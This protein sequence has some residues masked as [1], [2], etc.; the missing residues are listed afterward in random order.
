M[1]HKDQHNIK[2]SISDDAFSLVSPGD[3]MENGVCTF[4]SGGSRGLQLLALSW[5]SSSN[6][7]LMFSI[8]NWSMSQKPARSE[9]T[10]RG[11]ALGFCDSGNRRESEKGTG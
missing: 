7:R 1:S 4:L 9:A 11:W 2:Q 6:L 5:W 3:I 10:G 8:D